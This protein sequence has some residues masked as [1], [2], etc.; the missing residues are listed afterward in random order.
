MSRLETASLPL[1]SLEQLDSERIGDG[2]AIGVRQNSLLWNEDMVLNI[3]PGQKAIPLNIIYDRN[4][5][6]LA[7]PGRLSFVIIVAIRI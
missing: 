3:A 7:F 5:E 1:I 4:A 6:E 2:D